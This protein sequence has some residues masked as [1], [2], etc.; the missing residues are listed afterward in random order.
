MMQSLWLDYAPA[1]IAAAAALA[2][3]VIGGVLT[4]I[5]P[6]YRNLN[7]PR[8]QPPDWAF[9]PAWTLIFTLTAISGVLAWGSFAPGA[10]RRT[11]LLLFALNGVLN[12]LW[13]TLF[14]R[15]KRP[16]WAL[17]ELTLLWASIVALMAFIAQGSAA[18]A[19]LLA[20]Y[21]AWVT[22]AG[23]LNATVVGL[24]RPFGR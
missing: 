5:G 6:W 10:D 23:V 9:A 15:M 8:W 20:P 24:N 11:L 14:F 7:K 19:W 16:D 1:V 12:V 2:V 17:A 13:S 21:L 4:E 22:F 3:A 18:A